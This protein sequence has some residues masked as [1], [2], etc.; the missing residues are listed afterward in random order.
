VLALVFFAAIAL[1]VIDQSQRRAL[2]AQLASIAHTAEALVEPADFQTKID[3]S[4][5][6]QLSAIAGA[7]VNSAILSRDGTTAITSTYAMPAAIRREAL[8]ARR[9][10][11]ATLTV[12]RDPIRLFAIPVN[13]HGARIGTIVIW[14]D[15]E[16]IDALD[17]SIALAFAL[18]IPLIAGI[19]IV[20]GSAIARRG[21]APLA[22][23]AALASEIEAHDLTQ[24]LSLSARNDE[25]GRLAAT[26]DRMLDRLQSAFDRERRFTSDASH[27][28]RAPLS[29]IR[30]EADLA[31][32]RERDGDEYRRALRAIAAEADALE[33]LTRDLLAAARADASV[34]ERRQSLDFGKLATSVGERFRLV[35]GRKDVHIVDR[36]VARA[37][38]RAD[39]SELERA[40]V[41]VLDNAVKYSDIGGTIDIVVEI[42][43]NDVVAYITDYGPGFSAEAL[44]L[45]F[46]RFWRDDD[47]RMTS[48]SGLGL[49][50]AQSIVNRCG[51]TITLSNAPT[52]GAI[53][54]IR[55][56]LAE[57]GAPS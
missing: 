30:A 13:A 26:L 2:D 48:G 47:A 14:R 6:S 12:D 31:L 17:R 11:Y 23:M 39:T 19:A 16:A 3:V 32:R 37:F 34:A 7:K 49:G 46:D 35:A 53:V 36:V 57:N 52:H 54:R 29:V 43:G 27:E 55:L 10:H 44:S 21:L 1:V 15:A 42:L 5:R 40:L 24:R 4:D 45:A 18:A 25:L 51:G 8:R 28:L 22:E 9:P 20:A 41:A 56:P 50:I 33:L 38:V